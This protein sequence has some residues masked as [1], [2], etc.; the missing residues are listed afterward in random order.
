MVISVNLKV[1]KTLVEELNK[2]ARG[3]LPKEVLK[4]TPKR[5]RRALEELLDGYDTDV[6]K[7]FKTFEKQGYKGMCIAPNIKFHSFCEHH[8][9]EIQGICHIGYI[10]TDKVLGLSKLARLVRAFAHRLQLQERMT[11]QIAEALMS[12]PLKPK[13]VIVITIAKH[14]CMA[15]R[16]PRNDEPYVNSI[17]RGIFIKDPIVKQE[18]FSL[19]AEA[20]K[21]R[22]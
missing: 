5:I 17:I 13:G 15:C 1:F 19:L 4:N 8:F 21:N 18:F 22:K 3:T 7:L 16:G 14:S 20:T 10:A 12:S 6:S 9:L 11:E 2:K